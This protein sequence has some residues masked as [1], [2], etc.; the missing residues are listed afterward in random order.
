MTFTGCCPADRDLDLEWRKGLEHE[1]RET[2]SPVFE[3]LADTMKIIANPLRIRI[4]FL[5]QKKDH[6]IAELMFV[7]KEPQNLLSYHLGVLHKAGLVKSYYRSRYKT[8]RL[9]NRNTPFFRY[10][11]EVLSS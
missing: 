6:S 11:H 2:S 8:Y 7:L 10:L 5:L 4:L 3:D 9:T 1:V